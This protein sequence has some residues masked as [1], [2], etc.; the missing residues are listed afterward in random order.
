MEQ[1]HAFTETRL[2]LL[3]WVCAAPLRDAVYVPVDDLTD[4][5]NDLHRAESPGSEELRGKDRTHTD[6]HTRS[7]A[8]L[9]FVLQG[10]CLQLIVMMVFKGNGKSGSSPVVTALDP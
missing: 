5:L 10:S 1:Q 9:V 7:L 8:D 3:V 6:T 2:R 4:E